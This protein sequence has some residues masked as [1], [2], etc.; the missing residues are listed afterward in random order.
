MNEQLEH[1]KDKGKKGEEFFL[2]WAGK[3]CAGY[4]KTPGVVPEMDVRIEVF[5]NT[6][7]ETLINLSKKIR[8]KE[9]PSK[10]SQRSPAH[11]GID[12]PT[13]PQRH[14]SPRYGRLPENRDSSPGNLFAMVAN[15]SRKW[16][17][18]GMV[19]SHLPNNLVMANRIRRT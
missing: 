1:L 19:R 3:W 13:F 6:I 14:N 4:M 17:S 8:I 16:P 5:G 7:K 10:T 9:F 15:R 11:T 12:T 18:N 2:I